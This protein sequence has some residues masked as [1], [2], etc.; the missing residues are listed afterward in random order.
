MSSGFLT[1]TTTSSNLSYYILEKMTF[2]YVMLLVGELRNH[3]SYEQGLEL[4]PHL[5]FCV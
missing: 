3:K 2:L 4:S 1:H 5:F